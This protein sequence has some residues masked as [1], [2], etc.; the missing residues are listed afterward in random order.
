MSGH[1]DSPPPER[2][3]LVAVA[4]KYFTLVKGLEKAVANDVEWV[5]ANIIR[6]LLDRTEH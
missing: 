4:K 2:E 6:L 3:Q 5:D 1:T